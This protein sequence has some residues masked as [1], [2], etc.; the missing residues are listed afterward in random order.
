MEQD[1][2]YLIDLW[3]IFVREWRWF[4][5][6]LV[7]AVAGALAFAHF[8]T[9]EW[10]A[11]AWIQLGQVG[12]V[13]AGQDSKTEPL[14]RVI[15]RLNLVP[16][17]NE[18]LK[19]AGFADDSPEAALYRKSLK[20]EPLPY[21]GPLIR[22]T[23]RANSPELASRLAMATVNRLREVQQPLEAL[24]LKSARAHLAQ[25]DADLQGALAERDRM[26]Q[27]AASANQ[28]ESASK[29]PTNTLLANM[30]LTSKNQ[31]VRGLQR[32]RSDLLDRLSPTYT[33]ETSMPWPIY[34]PRQR[35]FPNTVLIVG[36]GLLAGILL[37]ALAAI[38]RNLVRRRMQG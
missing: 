32:E 3:R 7:L 22:I 14:Q 5:A 37:G 19:S 16:F 36:V 6:W 28:G 8:A 2:V 33:Y 24:P 23:L 11:T 30:L 20:L 38:T 1:E 21:A 26:Q 34:V 17:K 25:V 35:A 18:I 10:E 12:Q 31:E 29:S 27:A 13:P 9:R 15:E 4:I